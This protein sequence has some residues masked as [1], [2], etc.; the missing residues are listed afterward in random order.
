VTPEQVH[1]SIR[2]QRILLV[3]GFIL[4]IAGDRKSVV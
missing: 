4:M 3:M 1:S 2:R